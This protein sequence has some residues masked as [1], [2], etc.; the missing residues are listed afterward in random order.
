MLKGLAPLPR[1]IFTISVRLWVTAM[2]RGLLERLVSGVDRRLGFEEQLGDLLAVLE[3][4][5]N[6]FL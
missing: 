4:A 3:T 1:S 5:K 2:C 6:E